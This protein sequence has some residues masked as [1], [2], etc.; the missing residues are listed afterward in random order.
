MRSLSFYVIPILKVDATGL[1]FRAFIPP[2]LSPHITHTALVALS[3]LQGQNVLFFTHGKATSNRLFP[4]L[5]SMNEQL[6]G[7]YFLIHPPCS[8][9]MVMIV[10]L[11][12]DRN[13]CGT[14]SILIG[15]C[16]RWSKVA[17]GLL[18]SVSFRLYRCCEFAC[19]FGYL[20][21]GICSR[22]DRACFCFSSVVDNRSV[23]ALCPFVTS[24]FLHSLILDARSLIFR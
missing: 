22:E 20:L 5:W 11:V 16:H 24:E 10:V 6:G 15:H 2:T 17:T 9:L 8:C 12:G 4:V 1:S 13:D 18:A 14:R 3:S 21:T 23:A 7:C 19:I